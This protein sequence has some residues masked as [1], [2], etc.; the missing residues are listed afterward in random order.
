M[1]EQLLLPEGEEEVT[2]Y[3]NGRTCCTCGQPMYTVAIEE[4]CLYCGSPCGR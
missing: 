2:V 1:R 3:M 4:E